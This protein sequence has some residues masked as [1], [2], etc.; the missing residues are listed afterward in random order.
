MRW[1]TVAIGVPNRRRGNRVKL[2]E[3]QSSCPS[4][5]SS[6]PSR[7][8][9]TA[10]RPEPGKSAAVPRRFADW[11]PT[12]WVGVVLAACAEPHLSETA[13]VDVRTADAVEAPTDAAAAEIPPQ[14]LGTDVGAA[15]ALEVSAGGDGEGGDG[16]PATH[17]DS[18]MDDDG[19]PD[20]LEARY[21]A[22]PT[23]ADTDLDGVNDGQEVAD[24]TA[25]ADP[26]S[27]RAWHPELTVHPRLFFGPT[28]RADL[29][30][31]TT[32]AG[33][34]WASVW[35]RLVTQAS[36]VLPT[37]G[38]GP[39]D[40]AIGN[41]LARI[42]QAAAFVGWVTDDPS[43]V[44]KAVQAIST[45]F[46][47]PAALDWSTKFN[48]TESEAL[49]PFCTAWDIVAGAAGVDPVALEAARTN[50]VARLDA[51]RT[52]TH[53]GNLWIP[54][55]VEPNNHKMK[56][57]TAL[58]L[59]ALALND[60]P[61]AA[62]DLSEA[63]AG[64]DWLFND[65]Q[66]TDEGGYAEGWNY[67]T[68]GD[69]NYLPFFAA[70]HRLAAGEVRP[71]RALGTIMAD[72]PWVDQI[73]GVADFATNP[74][75]RAVYL[76]ALWAVQPDG[77]MVN[78]DDANPTPLHGA[79]LS[80]LFDEPAFLWQ[81][82]RPAAGLLSDPM[83]VATFALYDGTPAPEGPGL[84]LEGSATEAGFAI[85]RDS[86]KDDATFF[87]LQ[88]EHG[89][90]RVHAGGHEH[91]DELSFILWHGGQPLLIDPGYI[92]YANH[93]LVKYTS[94]H[95]SILVDGVGSP[96]SGWEVEAGADSFLTPMTT[97]GR[98]TWV[99]V[100]TTY[101]GASFVRTVVRLDQHWFVIWDQ[102]DAAGV[103]HEY[104]WLLNGMAG[105]DVPGSTFEPRSDGARWSGPSAWL[106]AHVAPVSGEA[107]LS[108]DLQ[109]HATSWG[110]WATHERLTAFATMSELA[111]FLTV[112]VPGSSGDEAPA[113]TTEGPMPGV[114][115]MT[116]AH[117]SGAW[118]VCANHSGV[119]VAM[120]VGGASVE[121]APGLT[122]IAFGLDGKIEQKTTLPP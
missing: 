106:E 16:G 104:R 38:D 17:P 103:S 57:I 33:T 37:Y 7:T 13:P 88:G 109:E 27:A 85:F 92:N 111:G 68:Y 29:A 75:T 118:W 10:Q 86:W 120:A 116:L 26:S 67:L 46:P 96:F 4:E 119:V 49:T 73:K 22:D 59:C 6:G 66:G 32:H 52:S 79:V 24:G 72:H 101:A 9:G 122:L 107:T 41:Q 100:A 62:A 51:F 71:Y 53:A 8:G 95:N 21:G 11:S 81:W 98:A 1:T 94:D 83:D 15:I 54:V 3:M 5:A 12:I 45:P 58:G 28:A 110:A 56:V 102:I 69:N 65:Y 50:L 114:R 35:E 39:L 77:L 61:E 2:P 87:W 74:R 23:R 115:A 47:D 84:P 113:V 70:Y 105:G 93:D 44:D 90:P 97:L 99:G 55:L 43:L 36:Q 76:R 19:L 18:D 31:R 78:T 91:A 25:P 112:L 82:F 42:A 117:S 121:A 34:A 48:L 20:D 60:R 89:A 30:Y 63:M 80:W 14:D 40:P 64:M 108:H